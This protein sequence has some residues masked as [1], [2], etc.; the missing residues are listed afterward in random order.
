MIENLEI[1]ADFCVETDLTRANIEEFKQRFGD[2]Q[3]RLYCSAKA[4]RTL[5]TQAY[6]VRHYADN[7]KTVVYEDADSI[8]YI[9]KWL[10]SDIIIGADDKK[11]GVFTELV[12]EVVEVYIE[13]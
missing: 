7:G 13:V 3:L 10:P 5:Q 4:M 12:K 11:T 8:W 6:N 1:D 9:V 2:G